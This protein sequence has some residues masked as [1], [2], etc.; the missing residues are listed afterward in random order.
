MNLMKFFESNLKKNTIYI[1]RLFD[2]EIYENVYSKILKWAVGI[3]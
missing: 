2:N 1:S 3:H